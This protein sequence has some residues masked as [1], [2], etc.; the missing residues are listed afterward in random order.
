[1]PKPSEKRITEWKC[2][3]CNKPAVRR[4]VIGSGPRGFRY[5][6]YRCTD[7]KR[8]GVSDEAR[9]EPLGGGHENGSN[10]LPRIVEAA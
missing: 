8:E 4:V 1:M 3:L 10:G 6:F 7:H 2:G 5:W 9:C